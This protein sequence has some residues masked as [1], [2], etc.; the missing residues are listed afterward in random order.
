MQ[1]AI[2]WGAVLWGSVIALAG[3]LYCAVALRDA[4]RWR[5]L[6]RSGVTVSAG[7]T[8][9]HGERIGGG[10]GATAPVYR[11]TV[12][13][14]YFDSDF[15]QSFVVD[16]RIF[17]DPNLSAVEVVFDRDDPQNAMLKD[18]S[19]GIGR[20]MIRAGGGLAIAAAGLAGLLLGLTR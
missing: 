19:S 15:E 8:N 11:I 9:R 20:Q 2:V 18:R 10:S 16:R 7:V 14:R 4:F 13:W 6:M 17:A 5:R 3:L 12:A 1:L